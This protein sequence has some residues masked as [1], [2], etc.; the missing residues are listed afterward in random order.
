MREVFELNYEYFVILIFILVIEFID[1]WIIL[2][3]SFLLWFVFARQIR[4]FVT[5]LY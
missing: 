1:L 2:L 5:F 3:G 4:V